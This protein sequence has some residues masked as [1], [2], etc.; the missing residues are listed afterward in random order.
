M[1]RST[2]AEATPTPSGATCCRCKR[3]TY[4]PV[5]VGYIERPSGPGV[6]LYACPSHAVSMTPSPMPGEA[7]R[8]A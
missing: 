8:P 1:T 7:Q 2:P 5:E 4:A 3:W 6:T